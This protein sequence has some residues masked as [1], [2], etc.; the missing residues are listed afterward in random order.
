[1]DVMS[2]S[3]ASALLQGLR[4]VEFVTFQIRVKQASMSG[5]EPS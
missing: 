5:L 1:L 4:R 2:P 3:R